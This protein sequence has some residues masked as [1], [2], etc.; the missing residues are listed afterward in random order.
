MGSNSG[1]FKKGE[2]R[3][4]ATEF[5]PGEHWRPHQQ[6]RDAD[7]LR[8]E[9]IENGRSAGD[10][11]EQFGVT[12]AAI[13]FWLRKHKIPRRSTSEARALKHW[14]AFG[15]DN[16]MWNK[17]GELN[18]RW[19]G[20]VTPERQAFYTSE[21]WRKACSTVW[22]RDNARCRRC[23]LHRTEQPD[24]PFHIHHIISFAVVE[25]RSDVNNLVLLCEVCHQFVHSRKNVDGEYLPQVGDS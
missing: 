12:D 18:P 8:A 7:W 6:F 3:S 13:I 22:R 1:Q 19:L 15:S 10:I 14:G 11:A 16:P 24:M 5:K 2:R 17:R 25:H 23:G 9:Y 21:E 20:G 4:P